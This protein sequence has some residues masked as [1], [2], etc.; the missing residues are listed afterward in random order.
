MVT[1]ISAKYN[2]GIIAI[3]INL[4]DLIAFVFL[5]VTQ[6]HQFQETQL[7]PDHMLRRHTWL[8]PGLSPH[9]LL[10]KSLLCVH[11]LCPNMGGWLFH[12]QYL[13]L[14]VYDHTNQDSTV[15]KCHFTGN[16]NL[17]LVILLWNK[18]NWN[19]KVNL[20]NVHPFLNV[21]LQKRSHKNTTTNRFLWLLYSQK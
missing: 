1:Y 5:A 7:V 13:S 16:C 21:F 4:R 6:A 8:V 14:N 2:T 11:C 3:N 18:V 10:V 12:R 20:S 19:F 15:H 17:Y 9:T